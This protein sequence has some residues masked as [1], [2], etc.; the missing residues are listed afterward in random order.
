MTAS[1]STRVTGEVRLILLNLLVRQSKFW[2]HINILM[3]LP[4]S[5]LLLQ[6]FN[7]QNENKVTS[8]VQCDFICKLLLIEIHVWHCIFFSD[9]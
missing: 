5:F 3:E 4:L 7:V 2:K 8:L 1:K 6:D 9:I